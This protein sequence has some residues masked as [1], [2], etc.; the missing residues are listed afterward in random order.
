MLFS[1]NR[2]K[3]TAPPKGSTAFFSARWQNLKFYTNLLRADV[4]VKRG[5]YFL[6][7]IFLS[8]NLFKLLPE[9]FFHRLVACIKKWK[10]EK[11]V[12]LRLFSHRL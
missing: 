11:A 9:F 7:S 10:P 3:A 4:F 12:F 5:L 6:I 2:L 8:H 1:A